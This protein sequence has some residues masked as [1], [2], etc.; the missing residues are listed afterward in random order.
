MD[1]QNYLDL[2]AKIASKIDPK[3]VHPNPRV[4]CVIVRNGEVVASGVHERLGEN[5]A[6]RNAIKELTENSDL[7][8]KNLGKGL[9]VYVSLEPCD[10]FDGKLTLSCTELLKS[11]KPDKVFVGSK[12]P[13]FN[14][15]NLKQLT[16]EGILTQYIANKNCEKL[17][18]HWF[19]WKKRK[20]P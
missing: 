2:A 8:S 12:D 4:G 3:K 15:D 13:K 7:G 20:K 16:E 10:D 1:H 14:G 6:E 19:L 18:K 11:L 5:H 17:N 9:E